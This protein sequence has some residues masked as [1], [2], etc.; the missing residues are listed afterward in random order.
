MGQ[1]AEL[2]EVVGR[3]RLTEVAVR[4][5]DGGGSCSRMNWT[6]RKSRKSWRQG[7]RRLRAKV[8]A[9]SIYERS[10]C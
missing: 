3:T 8:T 1:Q 4:E 7:T 10:F 9:K 5:G 2:H 6:R